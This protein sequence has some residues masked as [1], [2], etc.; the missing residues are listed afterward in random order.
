MFDGT[1]GIAVSR[2]EAIIAVTHK[3]QGS[4]IWT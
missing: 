1:T 3:F 2:F 4:V